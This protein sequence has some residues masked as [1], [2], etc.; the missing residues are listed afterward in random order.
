MSDLRW[1]TIPDPDGTLPGQ[2]RTLTEIKM[3]MELLTGQ[4]GFD[5]SYSIDNMRTTLTKTLNDLTATVSENRLV[6]VNE[7]A[8][9]AQR[10][11]LIE[12]EITAARQ[13][14]PSLNARI[15][16]VDTA[17][18]S[19]DNGIYSAMASSFTAVNARVDNVSGGGYFAMATAVSGGT[20]LAQ[21]DAY[22]YTA[23][24]Y[25]GA[26]HAGWRMKIEGGVSY[27]DIYV[28]NFR[29]IDNSGIPKHVFTYG[30]GKFL[31][32][33]DVAI[34]GGLTIN[35]TVYTEKVAANAI[36]QLGTNSSTGTAS[37]SLSLRA[38]SRVL[39]IG[40][41]TGNPSGTNIY[42]AFATGDVKMY[43]N[44]GEIFNRPFGFY[45]DIPS[46]GPGATY[47]CPLPT[48]Y[49]TEYTAGGA[50]VYTFELINIWNGVANGVGVN[51]ITVLELTR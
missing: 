13:G 12:A 38:G 41:T 34:D 4:R 50:G 33:G 30:G 46:S 17:S 31:F 23:G 14:D 29:L 37:V 44:G 6:A 9:L 3:A 51:T 27:Y 2:L 16:S 42:N 8:A 1:P 24:P 40:S 21:M 28:A 22:V 48:T 10:T 7:N 49:Q 20:A 43:A 26:V 15:V 47:R 39:I 11:T 19:R 32:T 5:P 18:V 25:S 45:Q 35:G 36:T